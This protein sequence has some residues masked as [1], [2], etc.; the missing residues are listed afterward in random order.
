MSLLTSLF[1]QPVLLKLLEALAGI[2]TVMSL[3]LKNLPS[4]D[5]LSKKELLKMIE[6]KDNQIER[7]TIINHAHRMRMESL[8]KKS[9]R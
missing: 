1:N 9:K 7:L 8:S 5:T 6:E 2:S 4:K 3:V